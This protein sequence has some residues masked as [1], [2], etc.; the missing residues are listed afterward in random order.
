MDYDQ[1][2]YA[3]LGVLPNAESVVI[4][5]AYRALASL[6]HPDRWKGD[7]EKATNRMAEINAA[8]AVLGDLKK[9]QEY[10]GQRSRST[11][12]FQAADDE[13]DQAFDAAMEQLE[14]RW[15]LAV[16]VIPELAI[17]RRNL[18]KTAHRLAFAFVTV[19]LETKRFNDRTDVAVKLK[20]AFLQRHFGSNP[21]VVAFAEELVELGQ[22]DAIKALNR[23]VDV[24]GSD[25]HS[26]AIIEKIRRDF[27][28]SEVRA[29]AFDAYSSLERARETAEK[30]T[31][32]KIR[33][34]ST[35]NPEDSKQLAHMLGYDV[36]VRGG[37]LFKPDLYEVR[38]RATEEMVA[39][40]EGAG[41]FS[42][43]AAKTLCSE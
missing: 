22:K 11:G 6:Y 4:V 3:I 35:R 15:A 29:K 21:K 1:D 26:T 23:Y 13:T 36:S 33:V 38:L 8:Y 7:L 12:G 41:K 24:L 30:I 9:R 42:A 14:E 5:A 32:L 39:L 19:M 28:L 25:T 2:F 10:D 31:Q 40:I 37:G 20:E 27:N 43:W 34:Q 18:E 17:I 16:S